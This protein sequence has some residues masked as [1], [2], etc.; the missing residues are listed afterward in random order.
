[1][2]KVKIFWREAT[3]EQS[4]RNINLFCK[5]YDKW[6]NVKIAECQDDII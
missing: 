6:K 5:N 1:M 4:V 3:M 2:K